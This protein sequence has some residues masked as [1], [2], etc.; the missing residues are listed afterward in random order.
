[1]HAFL[2][3]LQT[4]GKWTELS[5][6]PPCC[7]PTL[8]HVTKASKMASAWSFICS[9]IPHA[10][11]FLGFGDHSMALMKLYPWASVACGYTP[12]SLTLSSCPMKSLSHLSI[13]HHHPSFPLSSYLPLPLHLLFCFSLRSFLS[14]EGLHSTQIFGNLMAQPQAISMW[15]LELE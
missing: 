7:Q 8:Q 14:L 1:M 13:H 6:S 11:T 9:R 5:F 4:F 2:A 15:R 3:L 10:L 12:S